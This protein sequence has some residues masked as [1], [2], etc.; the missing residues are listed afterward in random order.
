MND[1]KTLSPQV[2]FIQLES[3]LWVSSLGGEK[4]SGVFPGLDSRD[5]NNDLSYKQDEPTGTA[6]KRLFM[7]AIHALDWI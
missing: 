1:Q 7:G 2:S 4:T 3:A 6:A 5:C